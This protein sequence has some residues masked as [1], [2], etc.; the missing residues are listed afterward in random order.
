[1]ELLELILYHDHQVR[2]TLDALDVTGGEY[3]R[4]LEVG[5]HE[6]HQQQQ[7]QQPNQVFTVVQNSKSTVEGKSPPGY[8][9]QTGYSMFTNEVLRLPTQRSLTRLSDYVHQSGAMKLV[10]VNQTGSCMFAAVMCC[11]NTL[12]EYTNMHQLVKTFLSYKEFFPILQ[13][14]ITGNYGHLRLSKAVYDQ[15]CADDMITD[16]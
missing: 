4:V 13:E 3:T 1:M 12:A 15:K 7:Q 6:S 14:H 9:A 5:R 11:T 8:K 16:M 10:P 2:V